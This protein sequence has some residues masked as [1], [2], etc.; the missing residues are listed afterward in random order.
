[1]R[2][3]CLI[4]LFIV[5]FAFNQDG[6]ESTPN[7]P[8]T[9]NQELNFSVVDLNIIARTK[10]PDEPVFPMPIA[11]VHHKLQKPK[12]LNPNPKN[13]DDSPG[14]PRN[15]GRSHGGGNYSHQKKKKDDWQYHHQR[16]QHHP[17][18]GS[19]NVNTSHHHQRGA[20]SPSSP[21]F[22]PQPQMHYQQYSDT[23][24]VYSYPSQQGGDQQAGGSPHR[25]FLP[26]DH[27]KRQQQILYQQFE[28]Q[29]R[30]AHQM[31]MLQ[32]Q[33]ESQRRMLEQQQQQVAQSS[34]IPEL[35]RAESHESA[36]DYPAHT[37]VRGMGPP[38]PSLQLGPGSFPLTPNSMQPN[39]TSPPQPMQPG[40]HPGI[41]PEYQYGSPLVPSP[42]AQ[43]SQGSNL[44]GPT[45]ATI[46]SPPMS[47]AQT[48]RAAPQAPPQYP[49]GRLDTQHAP[50][51]QERHR[52]DSA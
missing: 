30:H 26:D 7:P 20:G 27:Y 35:N 38:P 22:A 10:V 11:T 44:G 47:P 46:I 1:M 14:T 8:S 45:Y 16:Q 39:T 15:R 2:C 13:F 41:N 25:Q 21:T 43:Q 6:I 29:Q 33:Q 32:Q 51:K 9:M 5:A 42:M 12:Q 17:L 3:V 18:G 36:G 40:Q 4:I 24:S 50:D 31:H 23:N 28:L 49:D 19:Q 52:A 48:S 37:P 34:L